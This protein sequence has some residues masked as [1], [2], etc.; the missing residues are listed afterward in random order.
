MTTFQE[1]TNAM[2]QA[3]ADYSTT[4]ALSHDA[5]EHLRMLISDLEQMIEDDD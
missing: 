3:L 5:A 2:I 1:D 4:Y